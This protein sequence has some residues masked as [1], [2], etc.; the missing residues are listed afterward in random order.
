M[1]PAPDGWP[2]I[3]TAI[4][5]VD[6]LAAIDWLVRAFGFAVKI[7]VVGD[8]GALHHSELT[9]GGGMIMVGGE[10]SANHPEF[11]PRS[12]K[13]VG[14]ANTQTMM[15]YVDDV[16][17]FAAHAVSCGATIAIPLKTTDYGDGYWT[18]RNVGLVDIEGHHWWFA[19]RLK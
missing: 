15:V 17:A 11:K 12:P 18:D 4:T 8:D 1:K 9:F 10:A 6:P 2:R 13:S 14:G 7:K 16:D 19:Q 3:S 5:Y